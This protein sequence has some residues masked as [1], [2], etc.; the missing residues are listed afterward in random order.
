MRQILSR[1]TGAVVANAYFNRINRMNTNGHIYD[2]TARSIFQGISHEIFENLAKFQWI[3][4]NRSDCRVD[5]QAE[6]M[7]YRRWTGVK[8][9]HNGGQPSG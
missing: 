2:R 8:I 6:A 9:L 7:T 5:A 4:K 3:R 1:D